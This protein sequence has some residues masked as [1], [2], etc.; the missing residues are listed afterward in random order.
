MADNFSFERFFYK[1]NNSLPFI[2]AN[3]ILIIFI[4]VLL[5]I[6]SL[7]QSKALSMVLGYFLILYA[8]YTMGRWVCISFG[9]I[10]NFLILGLM[11]T[12]L[13]NPSLLW[14]YLFMMLASIGLIYQSISYMDDIEEQD[15][16][17]EIKEIQFLKDMNDTKE[18]ID[19]KRNTIR[20][21]EIRIE[22]YNLLN[23]I[24][25]KLSSTL[26][27]IEIKKIISN[28][29][30]QIAGSKKIDFQL[31]MWDE[32]AQ[33]YFPVE[34]ENTDYGVTKIY[35]KDPFDEWILKNKFTLLIKNINEDF[36]FKTLEKEG[37]NFK[38]MV[39]V[40]LVEDKRIIG[41]LKFMTEEADVFN[42]EDA[43][44]FNYLGD[45]CTTAVEN[46][47]LYK[48]TLQL[49]INDGLTG[50]YIRRYFL[51]K[52]EEEIRRSKQNGST[53]SFL[54]IDLDHFKECNDTYGH[55]AGDSVLKELG[56]YLVNFVRDVDIIGRYGGEEFAIILP[57]TSLNG[58]RFVAE[59]IRADFEK[60]QL[61]ISEEKSI[62]L[63]LSIGGV[64]FK[65]DHKLMEIV[66]MADKAL[67]HSKANG[68]NKVTFW[69][70]I[71]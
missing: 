44:L 38:S 28:A 7:D 59:R 55:L 3:M 43:R 2:I 50:L 67:Y 27:R 46:V 10:Y 66:N 32:D 18:D 15:N 1:E 6:I 57:D 42:T 22:N 24:A 21:N 62:K 45:V 36:R 54:M 25:R 33:A 41:I 19:K 63:T 35:N 65:K 64:E 52:L 16:M 4:I 11:L 61:K 14:G 68:R 60:Q 48:K 12:A 30:S 53:F 51:E 37:L 58:A 47:I 70:D 20:A 29:M 71:S 5:F 8:F 34:T 26:N 49:A 39:A 17:M 23:T 40:P 56:G 69:E 13:K 9:I 31:I